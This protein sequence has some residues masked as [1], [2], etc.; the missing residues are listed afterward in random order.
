MEKRVDSKKRARMMYT[1]AK[2][3]LALLFIFVLAGTG[4]TAWRLFTKGLTIARL[5]VILALMGVSYIGGSWHGYVAR[6]TEEL[7]EHENEQ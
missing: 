7:K 5:L 1:L 2:I 6:K 4:F 3:G